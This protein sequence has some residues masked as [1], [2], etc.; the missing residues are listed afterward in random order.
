MLDEITRN[1]PQVKLFSMHHLLYDLIDLGA[2]KLVRHLHKHN[3][4]I[5][6]ASGGA[7]DTFKIK[8]TN[9]K[10]FFALFGHSVFASTDPDVKNGK[11]A[12]DVFLTAADR[13]KDSPKPNKVC[14][15]YV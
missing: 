9:H 3:I 13:F 2:D 1:F 5:A 10:E 7:E 11:P 15:T 12:P 6:I 4:P 8:S 14:C